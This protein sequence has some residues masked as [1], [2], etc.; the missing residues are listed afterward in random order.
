MAI[1][2][3]DLLTMRQFDD[4]DDLVIML[5][6]CHSQAVYLQSKKEKAAVKRNG[7]IQQSIE[8]WIM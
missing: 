4:P 1:A 3:D 6:N 8:D 2:K 7:W 5:L